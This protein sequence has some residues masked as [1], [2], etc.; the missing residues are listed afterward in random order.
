[1]QNKC[2]RVYNFI[3]NEKAQKIILES[4]RCSVVS[5]SCNP[6]NCRSPGSSVHGISQ[7]GRLE[8]VPF[9]S[10]GALLHP[11]IDPEA[12]ALRADSSPS[13]PPGKP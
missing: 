4:V 8:W 5:D 2:L 11:G 9:P 10:P 13:E 12:P 7:A 3:L 6:V 1:M